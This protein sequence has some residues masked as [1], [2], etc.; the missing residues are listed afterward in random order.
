[1]EIETV[2]APRTTYQGPR[3]VGVIG[4][5]GS[6]KSQVTR[7]LAEL[8]AEVV[9]GD[10]LAHEALRQSELKVKVVQRWGRQIL[11]ADGEIQRRK[12]GAIV[13]AD[14]AELKELEEVVHRYIKCRIREEL[15][16]KR[17]EGKAPLLVLDAAIMIEAG[18]ADVCDEVVFVDVPQEERRLRVARQ[19]GW[20][21]KELAV[22]EGA[23]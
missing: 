8:G 17:S 4:G 15:D 16:R 6:G 10:E 11:G 18:W 20:T 12:L 21:E 19:R 13:F 5:I 1:M 2:N 14:P 7:L 22:R 3:V 23:Q 9:S